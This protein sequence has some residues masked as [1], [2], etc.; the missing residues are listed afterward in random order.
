MGQ[1]IEILKATTLGDV[2]VF[3]TDRSLTGMDGYS[4]ASAGQAGA[5]T[6]LAASL[7]QRIF[8]ADPTV[9]NVYVYSNTVSVQRPEGWTDDARSVV[10][11]EVTQFFVVYSEKQ[12]V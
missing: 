8:S 7:A 9:S 12:P 4:F 1:P 2:A 11:H 3:D 10:A 5:G 6:T